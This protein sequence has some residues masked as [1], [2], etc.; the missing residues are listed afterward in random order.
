MRR[1]GLALALTLAASIH[2]AD[3]RKIPGITAKDA[4]PKACVDCHVKHADGTD[5]R[6]SE[7]MKKWVAGADAKTVAAMQTFVPKGTTLKGK[8]PAI[9][10]L[11][12]VPGACLKCH[13]TKIAP[14]FAPLV[15]G[16]HIAR[17]EKSRFVTMF[18]GECTHCHKLTMTTGVW[19]LPSG[20]PK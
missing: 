18:Q 1:V 19:T 20:P 9:A 2:A 5:L 15:H 3:V 4:F 11:K 17:G 7:V 12:D 6:F 14:P 10:A 8:H 13:S 16:I